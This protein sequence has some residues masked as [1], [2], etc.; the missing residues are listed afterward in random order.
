MERLKDGGPGRFTVKVRAF[1]V[2]V[3]V[4]AATEADPG[5]VSNV[6]GT[7]AVSWV[8]DTKVVASAA[9]FQVSVEDGRKPVPVT[10]RVNAGLPA[11]AEDGLKL[12]STGTA[13]RKETALETNAL[14][15]TVTGKA[16]AAVRRDAGTAAVS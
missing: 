12:L 5:C 6:A 14:L 3:K 8:A 15:T 11:A 13:T 10:V 1:D 16:P 4:A 9:P 2:N 7:T